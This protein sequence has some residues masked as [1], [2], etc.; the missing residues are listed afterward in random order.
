[1][2]I[3]L[4]ELSMKKSLL[5]I[6][7]I[8]ALSIQA[9]HHGKADNAKSVVKQAYA[10]FS[11]GDT[12]A[13]A[14][15]HADDLIFT[16]FGDIPTSGKH[17][18]PSAVIKNVFEPIAMYWPNFNIQHKAIYS[19]GNIVFVHSD[20]TADGLDT[21]TLHM[22]RVENGIIQSFTAFDDTGSMATAVVK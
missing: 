10:T 8:C 6:I 17:I 13:W 9:G 16:V 12:E 2:F 3:N 20:M 5:S 7:F 22:F 4:S 21:E 1:M 19:D 11:S 14:A 18:G 15:L